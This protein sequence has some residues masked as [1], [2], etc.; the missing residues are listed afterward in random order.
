MITAVTS[1]HSVLIFY[2]IRIL[3]TV[4]LF[5]FRT[6]V[7]PTSHVESGIISEKI[8]RSCFFGSVIQLAKFISYDVIVALTCEFAV[9]EYQTFVRILYPFCFQDVT[10]ESFSTL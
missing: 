8:S 4:L 1:I 9:A 5:C 3:K 10:C 7:L 2:V 6:S